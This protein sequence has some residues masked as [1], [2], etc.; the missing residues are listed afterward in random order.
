ML[1]SA[2][3]TCRVPNGC[4]VTHPDSQGHVSRVRMLLEAN[5][6]IDN[7][8]IDI[9]MYLHIHIYVYMMHIY[10]RR[11][12]QEGDPEGLRDALG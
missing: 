5:A 10:R 2:Y 11:A 4:P 6:A 8:Y 3:S 9:D 1:P 7:A 12:R